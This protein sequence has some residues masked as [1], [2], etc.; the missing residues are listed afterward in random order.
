MKTQL[1]LGHL[2]R[3]GS[4]SKQSELLCTQGHTIALDYVVDAKPN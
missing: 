2:A 1:L 3:F 4:F